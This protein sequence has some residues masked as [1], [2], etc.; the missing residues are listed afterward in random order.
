MSS[1]ELYRHDCHKNA[2]II[3]NTTVTWV[4]V[5]SQHRFQCLRHPHLSCGWA[6]AQSPYWGSGD[7][8]CML[9]SREKATARIEFARSRHL[10]SSCSATCKQQQQYQYLNKDPKHCFQSL[11]TGVWFS[12]SI[13][14]AFD[15]ESMSRQLRLQL[16]PFQPTWCWKRIHIRPG[17]VRQD[18]N[19]TSPGILIVNVFI[20]KE[21]D[22][23]ELTV[24][25]KTSSF[26]S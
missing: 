23:D 5:L 26:G 20:H 1:I 7:S 19:Q 15:T 2:C 21:T 22:D 6:N 10:C 16:R 18:V 14:L 9:G 24:T 11:S 17:I 3:E 12:L 25:T 8:G 13:A 4:K